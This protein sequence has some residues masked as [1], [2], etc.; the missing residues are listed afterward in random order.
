MLKGLLWNPLY[1][2]GTH[3]TAMYETHYQLA[4]KAFMVEN[5][6]LAM[7]DFLKK[8][9]YLKFY[10]DRALLLYYGQ[11]DYISWHWAATIL[12]SL[13]IVL[14]INWNFN[15]MVYVTK[16][17]N[18]TS[19]KFFQYSTYDGTE[20]EITS[21]ESPQRYLFAWWVSNL[22][23]CLSFEAINTFKL[24]RNSQICNAT[25]SLLITPFYLSC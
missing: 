2:K 20:L 23:Y 22:S 21:D 15:R 11:F 18:N 17:A 1:C 5:E 3:K 12:N 4:H 13:L 14:N 8:A 10:R 24:P 19:A 16:P 6:I 9:N 25:L 7:P